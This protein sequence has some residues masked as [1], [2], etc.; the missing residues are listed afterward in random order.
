LLRFV[1]NPE[2]KLSN[3]NKDDYDFSSIESDNATPIPKAKAKMPS[4][5]RGGVRI[6]RD[7]NATP[8][9]DA[10]HSLFCDMGITVEITPIASNHG[11]YPP[12]NVFMRSK[13]LPVVVHHDH[14]N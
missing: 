8:I 7:V 11:A 10:D 1:I 6:H 3:V 14:F 9:M 13:S 5:N 12:R 2:G 4:L